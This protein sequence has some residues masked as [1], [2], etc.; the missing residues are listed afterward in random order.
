MV[1]K[2]SDTPPNVVSKR[3]R[4]KT[5]TKKKTPAKRTTGRKRKTTSTTKKK[6]ASS[7]KKA[8]KK[9]VVVSSEEEEEEE[10]EEESS[11]EEEEEEEEEDEA[12]YAFSRHEMNEVKGYT[13]NAT[14]GTMIRSSRAYLN[15]SQIERETLIKLMTRAIFMY[16]S[17]SGGSV[18]FSK[19]WNSHVLKQYVE[20]KNR[21][22]ENEETKEDNQTPLITKDIKQSGRQVF[23]YACKRLEKLFGLRVVEAAPKTGSGKAHYFLINKF[24]TAKHC[25]RVNGEF[26][27]S[28][29][30]ARRGI[31][32][33]I[34]AALWMHSAS[35][36]DDEMW[37]F[38][39]SSKCGGITKK[40]SCIRVFGVATG[41]DLL[42]LFVKERYL[43][44]VSTG[45][46][47]STDRPVYNYRFGPR[48]VAEIG[49]EN[50]LQFLLDTTETVVESV[51]ERKAMITAFMLQ[52]K[53]F[54]D[55]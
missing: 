7:K 22:K 40:K 3:S 2:I 5:K 18:D 6:R 29:S 28:Q 42:K 17:I 41:N 25:F 55:Y 44:C 53:G 16:A 35:M 12:T 1:R 32:M 24:E 21:D 26:A 51:K 13:P 8:R 46:K 47:S 45:A 30:R 11:E 37:D 36:T 20:Q 9:R 39:G 54:F 49:M 31:L 38:L 50:V 10:E 19:L 14:S 4:P 27:D 23:A 48:T 33:T 52:S 43:K 34:L 15:L